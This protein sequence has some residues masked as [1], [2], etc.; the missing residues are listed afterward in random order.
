MVFIKM[1]E[2]NWSLS[3]EHGYAKALRE[4]YTW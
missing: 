3:V 2:M 4:S 1:E